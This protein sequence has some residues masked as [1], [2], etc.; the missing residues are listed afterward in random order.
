MLHR[1]PAANTGRSNPASH[2]LATTRI[3]NSPW[4]TPNGTAA[5]EQ[6]SSHENWI[7][8]VRGASR[9]VCRDREVQFQLRIWLPCEQ[10]L[11]VRQAAV[12]NLPKLI[13]HR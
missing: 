3:F 10:E 5:D 12:K 1:I 9:P 13:S 8:N 2:D 7:F 11:T 4:P 6:D